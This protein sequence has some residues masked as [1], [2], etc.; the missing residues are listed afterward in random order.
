VYPYL[1]SARLYEERKVFL[2]VVDSEENPLES[3]VVKIDVGTKVRASC[4]CPGFAIRGKCKHLSTA[5]RRVKN[6]IDY[7]E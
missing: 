7:I 3:Y 6:Y 2:L 4:S 5:M 1:V